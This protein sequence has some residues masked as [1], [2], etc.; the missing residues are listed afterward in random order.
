MQRDGDTM[1]IVTD[2]RGQNHGISPRYGWSIHSRACEGHKTG[3]V[4]Y[5]TN[6]TFKNV[7]L[8]LCDSG[9]GYQFNGE[10]RHQQLIRWYYTMYAHAKQ[11]QL[12][13]GFDVK[14]DGS[15]QFN[16]WKQSGYSFF[17]DNFNQ[18][19]VCEQDV[20]RKVIEGQRKSY[21]VQ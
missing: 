5:P 2:T 20:I 7:V 10:T 15:I 18:M 13:T 17:T 9:F 8:L 21:V 4:L 11:Y 16:T 19:N 14:S 1:L 3:L 6:V 12:L